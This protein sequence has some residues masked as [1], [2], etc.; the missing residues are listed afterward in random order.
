MKKLAQE[1]EGTHTIAEK[2]TSSKSLIDREQ[3]NGTPFT[4]ITTEEG[5]F[6]SIGK[7]KVTE[8]QTEAECLL[9]I[10]EKDWNLLLNT[11]TAIKKLTKEIE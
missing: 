10:E 9:Q 4:L 6:L 1:Q 8:T 2:Q 5:S 7:Y 3:I 11:V